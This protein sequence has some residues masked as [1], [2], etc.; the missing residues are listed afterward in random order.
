MVKS[1]SF[2]LDMLRILNTR[3]LI[4]GKLF[5]TSRNAYILGYCED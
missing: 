4:K 2:E 3:S 5:L 1:M